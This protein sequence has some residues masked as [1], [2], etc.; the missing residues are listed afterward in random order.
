VQLRDLVRIENTDRPAA[1]LLPPA[2]Q[3]FVRENLR[4]RLLGA[5]IAL[6]NH[7]DASFRADVVAAEALL[8]QYFDGRTKPV[9]TVQATLKLLAATPAASAMP[10]LT[11]SLEAVR[12]LRAAQERGPARA[13]AAR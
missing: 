3:Y 2:Q 13:P 8:K 12:A 1:A 10:T 5:R 9:Q 4:L 11:R 6:Q 7:D